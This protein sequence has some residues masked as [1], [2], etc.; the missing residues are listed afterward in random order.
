MCLWLWSQIFGKYVAEKISLQVGTSILC[1]PF[2][3]RPAFHSRTLCSDVHLCTGSSLFLSPLDCSQHNWFQTDKGLNSNVMP[4][5]SERTLLKKSRFQ[6]SKPNHDSGSFLWQPSTAFF[7]LKIKLVL[8]FQQFRVQLPTFPNISKYRDKAL[9][10]T[11]AS[12]CS[13]YRYIAES[14]LFSTGV[15]A[16]L[17]IKVSIAHLRSIL[18]PLQTIISLTQLP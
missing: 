1:L 5:Y 14:F 3:W 7:L 8:Y 4:A 15:K 11:D 13:L 18:R 17:H 9:S 12:V 6:S 10:F 16:W 2:T